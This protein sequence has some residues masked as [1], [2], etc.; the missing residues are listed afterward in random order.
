MF[1][2]NTYLRMYIFAK[3]VNNLKIFKR[4]IINVY[5][6]IKLYADLYVL[7]TVSGTKNY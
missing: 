3:C 4:K 5:I 7:E 6:L 2:F 1:Q